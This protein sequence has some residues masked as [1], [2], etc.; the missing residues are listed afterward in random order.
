ML[1]IDAQLSLDFILVFLVQI[2]RDDSMQI[3]WDN[4][5][6]FHIDDA[7]N[8]YNCIIEASNVIPTNVIN[9]IPLH[10][11]KINVRYN[12]TQRFILSP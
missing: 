7:V 3:L 6:Y 4:H 2:E 5:I 11:P 9:E 12:F 1:K 10:V 8:T